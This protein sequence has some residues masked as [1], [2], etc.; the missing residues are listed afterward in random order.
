MDA[1]TANKMV[2]DE[3]KAT[4]AHQQSTNAGRRHSTG[5]HTSLQKKY[6]SNKVGMG[7]WSSTQLL[8]ADEK[9]TQQIHVKWQREEK[10]RKK[11]HLSQQKMH[12][13]MSREMREVDRK[14]RRKANEGFSNW[15]YS[16]EKVVHWN[17]HLDMQMLLDAAIPI[18]LEDPFAEQRRVKE[19]TAT[20][21]M[22]KKMAYLCWKD[23]IKSG[24]NRFKAEMFRIKDLDTQC[25]ERMIFSETGELF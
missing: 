7:K 17:R 5:M 16:Q 18:P 2:D 20:D 9:Y 6:Q 14:L 4:Y 21:E 11:T 15:G 22:Q 8:P 1:Q 19:T 24:V 13:H 12:Q 23:S 3:K 10:K 25:D